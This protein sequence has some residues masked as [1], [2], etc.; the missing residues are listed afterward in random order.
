MRQ[1]LC[2]WWTAKVQC[3]PEYGCKGTATAC[4]VL[5][6]SVDVSDFFFFCS[7]AGER[8]EASEEVAGGPVLNKNRGR[9]RRFPR[10]EVREGEGR[11][12]NV[13]GERG[14]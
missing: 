14:S 1:K 5:I 2:S 8:E 13:C 12:G 9:G 4:F 11:R 6:A 10:E 7:G 3:N